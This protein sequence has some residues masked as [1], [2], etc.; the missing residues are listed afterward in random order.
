MMTSVDRG[1]GDKDD[2]HAHSVGGGH[3]KYLQGGFVD[4]VKALDVVVRIGSF[5]N[6]A[7][8]S[9]LTTTTTTTT[10]MTRHST[11][12]ANLTNRTYVT[13]YGARIPVPSEVRHFGETVRVDVAPAHMVERGFDLAKGRL[14]ITRPGHRTIERLGADDPTYGGQNMRKEAQSATRAEE[15]GEYVREQ[16]HGKKHKICHAGEQWARRLERVQDGLLC[17]EH[18]THSRILLC[19]TH[20]RTGRDRQQPGRPQHTQRTKYADVIRPPLDARLREH[21]RDP[22]GYD[23]HGVDAR[24]AV[25]EV[26]QVAARDAARQVDAELEGEHEHILLLLLL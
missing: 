9:I 22:K 2:R 24:P 1:A 12:L 10:A 3:D 16:G 21:K 17:R 4:S 26:G 13:L 5:L 7:T 8:P 14:Q 6:A 18:P 23:R 15:R 11:D 20:R 25:T 19:V